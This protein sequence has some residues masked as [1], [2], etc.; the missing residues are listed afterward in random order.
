MYQY[1]DVVGNANV[2][3]RMPISVGVFFIIFWWC[4]RLAQLEAQR[5]N[6]TR[7]STCYNRKL[8]WWVVS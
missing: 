7:N 1:I 5:G 4:T 3:E 8:V 2:N 6:S